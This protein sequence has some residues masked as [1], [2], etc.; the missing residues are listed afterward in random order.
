MPNKLVAE[1]AAEIAVPATAIFNMSLQKLEY[2]SKWKKEYATPIG[3]INSPETLDDIR[4][5]SMTNF[6]SKIFEKHISKWII[7]SVKKRIDPGQFG[8]TPGNS[9]THYLIHL[10]N[11][12]LVHL[13]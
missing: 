1:F 9:I 8:G 10:I 6:L 12:I 11:F 13:D 5:I 4:L 7:E 2:P 3:K